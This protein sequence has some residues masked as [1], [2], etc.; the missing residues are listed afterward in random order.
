MPK[1]MS[2]LKVYMLLRRIDKRYRPNN[3]ERETLSSLLSLDLSGIDITALP[4]SFGQLSSL[5]GL[6]LRGTPITALPESF[7]QLSGLKSL[8]LSGTRITALPE[9]FGQ[10]SKLQSL[11]LS[12]SP[13]TALPESFG[14]LSRLQRLDLS[15]TPIT[16]LPESFGKLSKL[17]SLDLS[18]SP[19]TALLESFGQLSN[20]QSLDL[21]YT[22]I[23]ALPESF[24][25]LASLQELYLN[26]TKIISLPDS[27]GNLSRLFRLDL[28]F[29]QI[30][31]LPDSI[32]NLSNLQSLHL[33]RVP[34][35]TLPDSF[36][37]LS[38]LQRLYLSGS[39][40]SAL[41]NSIGQLPSLRRLDLDGTRI[42]KLPD[43]FCQRSNLQ[44]LDL[45]YTAIT[46]LPES[47]EQLLFLQHLDLGS[48]QVSVLPEFI[49][50]LPNLQFLDLRGLTL[51]EI[52]KSLAL[53]GLPF[54][55]KQWD[56][57][58]GV[59]LY[60]TT[61]TGQD[62][63]VFLEHP[64][65]IA[66]LYEDQI[67]L[68]ESRVIFLGDGGVGKSYTIRRLQNGCKKETEKDPYITEQTPGIE[69]QDYRAAWGGDSYTLH[70]WD[71][72]G[73][74]ILHSMHRCFLSDQT[75]YVVTV[76]TRDDANQKARYWLRNVR[77]FAPNSL[78]LL[79]VNCW[80]N[81]DGRI[82]NESSL[83]KEFPNI[84]DVV[85]CSAK[86]AEDKVFRTELRDKLIGMVAASENSK[87][88][89]NRRWNAVRTVITEESKKAHYLTKER[90]R[91]LCREN[92][93][94]DSNA[95]GLLSFFN[96]L[97][98]CFSYHLDEDKNEL[99]DYKLLNPIWLTNAI[100][101]IIEEGMAHA[102]EGRIAVGSIERM[103]G[104]HAPKTLR[105]EYRRTMPETIYR[106]IECRY[107]LEVAAAH[108]L[109]YRVNN[110]TVFFP[111]L[112]RN[113][114]PVEALTDPEG[115]AQHVE[116]LL[117]Y[118]YLPDSVVH[119]LMVRCMH[120][121]ITV[122]HCWLQGMVL[123]LPF[124]RAVVSMEN[125]EDLHLEIWSMT[126]HPAYEMFDLLR[127]ELGEINL[128][129]NLGTKEYIV[130]GKDRYTLKSLL[131]AAKGV[132]VV[133]GPET[134]EERNAA[135]L[136]GL[137]FEDW[138]LKFIQVEDG[139]ITIPI[140]PRSFHPGK[141]DDQNLRRAL[142]EAYHQTC[143]YCRRQILEYSDMQVEHIFPSS[144]E[145]KP[146]LSEYVKYLNDCG[147][148]TKKPDYVE[149]FLPV[150]RD[151]N[152]DRSNY[153][154]CFSLSAWHTR[155]YSKSDAVLKLY[156][157]YSNQT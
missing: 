77:A 1:K 20:L 74:E 125:D 81:A 5:Q 21:R 19:I 91:E 22:R 152:R 33:C 115:F 146:E 135:K 25:K 54:V 35:T 133:Y 45:S 121:S 118:E 17:Q 28:S 145:E 86:E 7:G 120:N 13:I 134:G 51:P 143:P 154:D 78:V 11:D 156:K 140:L 41:P 111:A 155:A 64:E 93:I 83:R 42:T 92:G 62:R 114:T 75:C 71:F 157:K 48:S 126:G 103:L 153:V 46:C 24:V 16:A 90:Y 89:V 43:T 63:T 67:T 40:L 37:R 112:C 139:K 88:T 127:R 52:P 119:Q 131:S 18:H 39:H 82:V 138:T 97:G 61:L 98:V 10:L 27:I 132:G 85:Y 130:D 101:A 36:G 107:V 72:G 151:C 128:R 6:H 66:S 12:H 122:D 65:L 150:H 14:Q 60:R 50:Q 141:Q 79:F 94:E 147:F 26:N 124:H 87:R 47:F 57:E 15:Y 99:E 56:I 110:N 144:Y 148:N 100:Y 3:E 96:T 149:N 116:Y 104:E 102:T 76:R 108:S 137:F 58:S 73:Q 44:S 129:L 80:E 32:G 113:S 4:E 109:C 136:L 84:A 30:T 23:T 29:A 2:D 53:C 68:R 142:Y 49:G 123:S 59:N 95:P 38:G 69:I 105:K 117:K 106:K 8:D 70:L 55:E 34:I 31:T 9:S